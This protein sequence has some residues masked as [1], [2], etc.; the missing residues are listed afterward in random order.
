ML[1]V[2]EVEGF[3]EL[4][5]LLLIDLWL[6]LVYDCAD[7]AGVSARLDLLNLRSLVV[8]NEMCHL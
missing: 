5:E 3:L 4:L 7:V 1:R 6:A 2:E 8:L